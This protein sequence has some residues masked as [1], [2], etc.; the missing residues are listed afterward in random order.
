M[1]YYVIEAMTS[2]NVTAKEVREYDA[3]NI[4]FM[5]FHQVLASAL[6]NGNVDKGFCSVLNEYGAVVRNEYFQK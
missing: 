5:N 6:A 1:K 3:E 4:A 2:N